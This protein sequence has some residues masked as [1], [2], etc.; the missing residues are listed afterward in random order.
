MDGD[1][2]KELDDRDKIKLS[3]KNSSITVHI[4][5]GEYFVKTKVKVPEDYPES[6]IR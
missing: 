4:Y 6:Q 1:E 3:Q 2:G 5:K